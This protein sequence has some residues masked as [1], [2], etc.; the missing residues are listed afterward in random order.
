MANS[1]RRRYGGHSEVS[2]AERFEY[3]ET[4]KAA[5]YHLE[6]IE[7][8]TKQVEFAREGG[9]VTT[10]HDSLS[11]HFEIT[12]RLVDVMNAQIERSGS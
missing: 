1:T 9:G 2:T 7:T 11:K 8:A 6:Q 12:R 10:L 4:R 3:D 5:F